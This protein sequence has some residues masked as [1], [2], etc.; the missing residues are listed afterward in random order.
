MSLFFRKFYFLGFSSQCKNPHLWFLVHRVVRDI[1][2][3]SL[4]P[5]YESTL[6]PFLSYLPMHD[7]VFVG[8]WFKFSCF[9]LNF[10]RLRQQWKTHTCWRILKQLYGKKESLKGHKSNA[11]PCYYWMGETLKKHLGNDFRS[12]DCWLKIF[13]WNQIEVYTFINLKRDSCKDIEGS[14][15]S[16]SCGWGL[17]RLK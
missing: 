9:P 5:A 4:Q 13:K 2:K 7:I 16:H 8:I 3:L 17:Q 12:E 1:E 10:Y 15:C 11:T 14:H 6:Q